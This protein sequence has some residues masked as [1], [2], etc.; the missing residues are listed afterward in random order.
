MQA[1]TPGHSTLM[2]R[3]CKT[4]PHINHGWLLVTQHPWRL[5]SSDGNQK[6]NNFT[7]ATAAEAIIS[8]WHEITDK[9]EQAIYAQA[10]HSAPKI[11]LESFIK[12]SSSFS[13]SFSLMSWECVCFWRLLSDFFEEA[14]PP[15]WWLKP[16]L[17][18]TGA[19]QTLAAEVEVLSRLYKVSLCF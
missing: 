14:H 8:R 13:S 12:D 7:D 15:K 16:D 18:E 9:R 10:Q 2:G 11:S 5:W 1:I 3:L 19:K 6:K 4:T 17:Q